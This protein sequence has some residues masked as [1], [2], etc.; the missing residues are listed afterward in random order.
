MR[1]LFVTAAWPSHYTFMVPLAWAWHSA[2]HE[3][4]VCAQPAVTPSVLASGLAAVTTGPDL[5]FAALHRSEVA[6]DA[7]RQYR[8]KDSIVRM[9]H[10]VADLMVDDVVAF[11]RSWRPDLIIRDPVAFAASVA[12]EAIGVP[13]IRH[14][15]GPDIFGTDQGAWLAHQMRDRLAP[16][17]ARHGAAV[18][19]AFDA[20]VVDPTPASVRL[21]S[22]QRCVPVRY[23]PY[24]GPGTVPPWAL[25]A[26]PR[27]RVLVTGGTSNSTAADDQAM[28]TL[29]TVIGALG[30]LDV[31]VVV[32][33]TAADRALLGDVPDGVRVVRDLPLHTLLPTCSAVVHHGGASTWMTAAYEGVPQVAVPQ[34]FDQQLNTRLLARAGVGYPIET[35]TA[36]AATVRTGVTE[37]LREDSYRVAA[38]RLRE[39]ILAEPTPTEVVHQLTRWR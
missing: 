12:A 17:Y 28:F 35:G 9:F 26:G 7:D 36:T 10:Q 24:N 18:P 37:V 8:A 6:G 19:E 11:A 16:A 31:E 29:P 27:P 23:V 1:V 39:E 2:G 3:V 20:L 13:L 21:V 34:L 25:T 30:D 5:D 4:R 32:A 38:A 22:P 33:V 15:W 14:A